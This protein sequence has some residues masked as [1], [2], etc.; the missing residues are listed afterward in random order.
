MIMKR[1]KK[2][3][4][5]TAGESPQ[6]LWGVFFLSEFAPPKPCRSLPQDHKPF[7]SKTHPFNLCNFLVVNRT[8]DVIKALSTI[9]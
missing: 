3:F 1:K 4:L 7:E 5:E 6:N 2:N 9:S 8:S